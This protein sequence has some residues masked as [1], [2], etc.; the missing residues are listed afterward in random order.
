MDRH[1]RKLESVQREASQGKWPSLPEDKDWYG[2]A[3][4]D[5]EYQKRKQHLLEHGLLCRV[6]TSIGG[7][8]TYPMEPLLSLQVIP[9]ETPLMLK[10]AKHN[11][12]WHISIGFH[13]RNNRHFETAFFE[14]YGFWKDV[15]LQFWS[16]NDQAYAQLDTNKCPIATD[17]V[18]RALHQAPGNH[19]KDRPLHV[20]F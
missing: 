17:P 18:I 8:S 3:P 16:I 14:K 9:L 19:Y 2:R 7:S 12:A 13:N 5:N 10:P 6:K 1:W 15:R 20:S 4:D 11:P